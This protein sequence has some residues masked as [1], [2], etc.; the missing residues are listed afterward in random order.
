MAALKEPLQLLAPNQQWVAP[1]QMYRTVLAGHDLRCVYTESM[2]VQYA[3]RGRRCTVGTCEY[4]M[5]RLL[6]FTCQ[7]DRV[8]L[9]AAAV[10]SAW[11]V[12][13]LCHTINTRAVSAAQHEH[14]NNQA[15]S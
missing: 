4:V 6:M 7:V 11:G 3:Q 1:L 15:E 2:F 12:P 13:M 14:M 9:C 5:V 8:Q 10:F